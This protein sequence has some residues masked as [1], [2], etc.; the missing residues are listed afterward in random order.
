ME[1]TIESLETRLA[2]KT[3]S[4]FDTGGKSYESYSLVD[5]K[6]FHNGLIMNNSPYHKVHTLIARQHRYIQKEAT[7]TGGN[8]E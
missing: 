1:R 6:L 2:N 4:F 3:M 7:K 8:G 5:W